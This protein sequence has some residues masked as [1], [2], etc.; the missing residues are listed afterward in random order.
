V[1]AYTIHVLFAA[2]F[3]AAMTFKVYDILRAGEISSELRIPVWMGY[4]LASIG[5]VVA[6]ATAFIRWAQVVFG[7]SS[8]EAEGGPLA[9]V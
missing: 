3:G 1:A 6:F 9:D 5:I 7:H 8:T 2:L 4:T